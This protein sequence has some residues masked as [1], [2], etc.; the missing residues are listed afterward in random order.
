[1][2]PLR[3]SLR[4]FASYED[5]E[6][7]FPH[8]AMVIVG[9]NGSGKSNLAR[10][11]E[12]A[13]YGDPSAASLVTDHAADTEMLVELVFEQDGE[14]YRVRRGY[15][16]R[17]RG[18]PVLDVDVW[19][20]AP[21]GSGS[22]DPLTRESIRE[23]QALI[24]RTLGVSRQVFCASA[25]A[26]EG[27]VDG[28]CGMPPSARR[29]LLCEVIGAD[30]FQPYAKLARERAADSSAWVAQLDALIEAGEMETM[31]RALHTADLRAAINRRDALSVELEAARGDLAA[32]DEAIA[33]WRE[34]NARNELLRSAERSARDRLDR[35][36]GRA[37][38]AR[39]RVETL[40]SRLANRGETET[41]AATVEER[42]TAASTARAEAAAV[43]EAQQFHAALEHT[44]KEARERHE[45][46]QRLA[47]EA[48]RD[49]QEAEGRLLA[50]ADASAPCA[51]CNRPLREAHALVV[52]RLTE[53]YDNAERDYTLALKRI[54]QT[55]QAVAVA[56]NDL[57]AHEAPSVTPDVAA[58]ERRLRQ[59]LDARALL[60]SIQQAEETLYA[61]SN[62][63]GTAISELHDAEEEYKAAEAAAQV[64][65]LAAPSRAHAAARVVTLDEAVRDA[66][67]V[68]VEAQAA[69]GR[70]AKVD[71]QLAEYRAS[72]T[73]AR[74]QH[75]THLALAK[76]YAPDGIPTLI[77]ETSAI[78]AI[79]NEANRI[80]AL[81]DQP[82]SVEL[83]TQKALKSSDRI[84][85]ALDV[86]IHT[87]TGTTRDYT[88][89]SNGQRT[90]IA[91]A[92]RIAVTR[93]LADSGRRLD[94]LVL[95]EPDG[96]SAAGADALAVLLHDL[97]AETFAT[98][99]LISHDERMI[100]RFDCHARIDNTHGSS[101]IDIA[102]CREEV[103]A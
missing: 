85:E 24:T 72:L 36:R 3:L 18:K 87:A 20:D 77:L 46:A 40:Q 4:N 50:A 91:L 98:V 63:Y 45:Q 8:G 67:R 19:G 102:G 27:Q 29:E 54:G 55:R 37:R 23:T 57:A 90:R 80:L 74:D 47:D 1:M 69:L 11:V 64:S 103:P 95:D 79:E 86:L 22:W 89:M 83:V 9:P 73:K 32:V 39:G 7:T 65:A 34:E 68:M 82:M 28:L 93:L 71:A 31:E 38:E 12:F 81:L 92:V 10:A 70:I 44:L 26:H 30:R 76:A 16:V 75:E 66:E 99:L 62:D 2:R 41:L 21:F 94:L 58:A 35:A 17:G 5:A 33:V 60:A 78:P 84:A 100:D 56:T 48:L 13:L 61:A 101:A 96:L 15:S 53:M 14:T 88:R 25:L 43:A 6:F 42:E 97:A 52:S 51:L 59:A 49:Y